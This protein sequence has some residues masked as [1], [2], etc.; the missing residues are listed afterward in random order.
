MAEEEITISSPPLPSPPPPP[1]PPTLP[2][3]SSSPRFLGYER[4]GTGEDAADGPIRT[5]FPNAHSATDRPTKDRH[6]QAPLHDTRALVV[7]AGRSI[8]YGP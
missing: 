3:S 2:S 5:A 4:V 1:P 7:W 6:H 8:V